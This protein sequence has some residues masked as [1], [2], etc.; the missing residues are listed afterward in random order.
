MRGQGQKDDM[1]KPRKKTL[2]GSRSSRRAPARFHLP[3]LLS[4]LSTMCIGLKN[5][6]RARSGTER[7][8]VREKK[9]GFCVYCE[10]EPRFRKKGSRREDLG[11]GKKREGSVILWV[12]GL[13]LCGLLLP[14]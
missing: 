3:P 10:T 2:C 9:E 7:E 12:D 14:H 6:R 11:D 5:T 8:G 4:R 13:R 1:T